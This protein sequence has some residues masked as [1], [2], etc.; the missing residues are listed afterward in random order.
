MVNAWENCKFTVQMNHGKLFYRD[1][2]AVH[3][4]IQGTGPGANS[5]VCNKTPIA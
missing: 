1:G 3:Y 5:N 2:L 4:A